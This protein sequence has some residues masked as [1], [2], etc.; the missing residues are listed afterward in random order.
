MKS[1]FFKIFVWFWVATILV[2]GVQFLTTMRMPAP[3]LH[4]RFKGTMDRMCMAFGREAMEAFERKGESGLRLYLDELERTTEIRGFLFR[5]QKP[6]IAKQ[7]IPAGAEDLAQRAIESGKPAATGPGR[8]PMMP[9]PGPDQPFLVAG[10]IMN[11]Q[12]KSYAMV[13]QMPPLGPIRHLIS[14]PE[15]LILRL[16]VVL[17]MAGVLCYGLAGYLTRP[18]RSLRMATRQLANGDLSV[19]IG[20]TIGK[21]GDEI[22]DLGRDF[23]FMAE[24]L[25]VLLTAQRQLM[26]DISHELRTPLTRLNIA[27]EMARKR[28]G[29]EATG[30]LNQIEIQVDRLNELIGQLLTLARLEGSPGEN[31]KKEIHL[32]ELITHIAEDAD[33]EAQSRN[34][35][36]RITAKEDATVMGIPELL[37]S[38][39][40]NVVRN[41]V[42]YTRE[43]TTVEI[44]L[45]CQT[46]G[47]NRFG[48]IR[49]RDHGPGVPDND[50][51]K[52]FQPFFRVAKTWD[53]HSKGVGLGL[54]ITDRS[55]RFHGGAVHV[56]N[57]SDGG[58]AVEIFLPLAKNSTDSSNDIP[59]N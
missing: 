44:S 41:A 35:Q 13:I 7:T 36:V 30:S 51:G 2:G 42:Y 49:V 6:V 27:L 43:N 4:D 50:I 31:P 57:V 8:P 58:F 59:P 33:F 40:E 16:A 26:W 48:V 21:R 29:E 45:S 23:D 46:S 5:G 24:R 10:P 19:R 32:S 52:I 17:L 56:A 18:L 12:G 22:G 25:E 11:N 15:V 14:N 53:Q 3:P 1:L 20:K 55:V 9:G 28:A 38:A 34:R 47:Q 39:V 54:T 37:Q